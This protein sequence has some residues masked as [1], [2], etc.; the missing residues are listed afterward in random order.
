MLVAH[1]D[2][3]VW[4]GGRR[5][6]GHSLVKD[7]LLEDKGACASDGFHGWKFRILKVV[8]MMG[9]SMVERVWRC[10]RSRSK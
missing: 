10:A 7:Q 6:K 8:L 5:K 1:F 9:S 2:G 3:V 4:S